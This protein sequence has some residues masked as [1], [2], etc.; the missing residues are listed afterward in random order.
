MCV[1]PSEHPL[2]GVADQLDLSDEVRDLLAPKSQQQRLH[3][4]A[5]QHIANNA[6]I[7]ANPPSSGH[8]DFAVA[9][10]S[11][12]NKTKDSTELQ[13]PGEKLLD[14]SAQHPLKSTG[15]DEARD[16]CYASLH[17]TLDFYN[18]VFRRNSVDGSGLEIRASVHVG[19]NVGDA[20]WDPNSQQMFFGDGGLYDE[21]GKTTS[22][23][24]PFILDVVGHE[25]THGVVSYTAGLGQG[26]NTFKIPDPLP[27]T[28]T[29]DLMK[30]LERF[31]PEEQEQMKKGSPSGI[32]LF[33]YN[34]PQ[35]SSQTLNEHIADCFGAM[36][37]QWSLK[38]TAQQADWLVGQGWWSQAT[39]NAQ[40]WGSNN[41]LRTF[42]KPDSNVKQPD[43]FPKIW[44]ETMQMYK[45][46]DSHEFAG[47]GN[48][49][50]Y[51]AALKFGGESWKTVGRIWYNALT[52]EEFK[53][54]TTQTYQ[55][56][57][58]LTIHH[59]KQLFGDSGA[60]KMTDAWKM[61]NL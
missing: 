26:R 23:L 54:G 30:Q 59:A 46:F 4:H 38:Q 52:D 11:M 14:T 18:K 3:K 15:N 25:F 7:T 40:N 13:A 29:P 17:T 24:S 5:I 60:Q 36:I 2:L 10:F 31:P 57:R 49:A 32:A 35:L 12:H 27:T 6:V 34:P 51:Q 45:T 16:K 61:V 55:A 43:T 20:F 21:S 58:D 22:N 44:R 19:A 56:W 33:V 1:I 48:H 37:K 28:W 41:Y 47:I 42:H 39:M 50:F 8:P 53:K 9:I